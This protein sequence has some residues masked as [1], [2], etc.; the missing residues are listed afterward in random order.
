MMN[1][2]ILAT[3]LAASAL[4]TTSV[5]ADPPSWAHAHGRRAHNGEYDRYGRYNQPRPLVQNDQVWHGR[6]GRYHCRRSNGTTGLV[7][8]AVGGALVGRTIDT[9]GD[10]TL[11]TLLGAAGGGLLGREID[12]SGSRCR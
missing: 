10:R 12:R 1:M 3:A 6:D 9:R 7:I 2:F 8:G 5:F 4:P 11:G